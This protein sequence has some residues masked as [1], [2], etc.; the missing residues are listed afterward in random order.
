MA[1]ENLK[2]EFPRKPYAGYIF[3]CDGTLADSMRL[4]HRAW[5]YALKAHG[6]TFDYTWELFN[7]LAGVGHA[8]TVRKLNLRFDGHLDPEAV[9]R[10]KE[11]WYAAHVE[12]VGPITPV[13]DYARQLAAKGAKIAVASGGPRSL[14]MRTLK[15]IR[16]DNAFEVIV[17]QDDISRSKPDPEIFVTAAQRLGVDPHQCVVFEDSVLGLAGAKA[18]GM[19]SVQIPAMPEN[20]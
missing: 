13:A 12:E 18:A 8:D 19:D 14:V 9:T 11:A 6:A 20:P 15:A 4:H 7:S 10:D 5:Q 2:I 1:F 16:L 3:D 17:T